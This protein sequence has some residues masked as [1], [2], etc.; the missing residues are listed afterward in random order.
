MADTSDMILPM[1]RE[2][3]A[4]MAERF[5]GVNRRF[6][7]VDGRLEAIEA[8]Q[9]SFRQALSADSLLSKLV[10]GEFQQRIELL[11]EKVGRLEVSK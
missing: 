11:E 9:R 8:A 10:T 6:D 3:R 4:E 1:L 7:A 5:E 2:L